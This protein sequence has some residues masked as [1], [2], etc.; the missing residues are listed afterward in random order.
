MVLFGTYTSRQ[1]IPG[2]FFQK[3]YEPVTGAWTNI[4]KMKKRFPVG[5]GT[6]F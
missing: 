4:M 1:K 3:D 6:L 5:T 2:C